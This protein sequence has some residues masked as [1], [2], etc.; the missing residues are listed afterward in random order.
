M[1][2]RSGYERAQK[3]DSLA[4]DAL[5]PT[6]SP[7]AKSLTHALQ[8][9]SANKI[10]SIAISPLQGQFLAIQAQLIGAKNILEI[11]TLGGYSTIWFASTGAK[12]T[13]L[14]IDSHHRDVALANIAHAGYADSV[15]IILGDALKTLPKLKEEGKK[16]DM[17]FI[18]ADWDYQFEFFQLALPL[19]KPNGCMY[20]DNVVREVLEG[21]AE[22]YETGA[23]ETL[24]Q[25]VGKLSAVQA[26]VVSVVSS[27]KNHQ[28]EA[29]D[30]FLMGIVKG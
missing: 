17:V 27:H 2:R 8:N 15:D 14:E 21:D 10:P 24:F 25:K 28:D 30:G 19:M 11:G 12:V 4:H 29:F 23:K 6:D 5:L 1:A 18:D 16:F 7:L 9:T 20:V 3:I 26:T 13:S 22:A